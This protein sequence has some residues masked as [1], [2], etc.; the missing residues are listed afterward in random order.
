MAAE[1]TSVIE[2][3]RNLVKQAMSGYDCSHDFVHV[4]RVVN[5]S[6]K[7]AKK[8]N[9]TDN[10]SLQI[11]ELAAYLHDLM[12]HKYVSSNESQSENQN[13]RQTLIQNHL[14]QFQLDNDIIDKVQ[15]IVENIS[16]SKE[17]KRLS[18]SSNNFQ[19]FIELDIV[20]DADRLDAIGAIGIVRC[21]SFGSSKNR[22]LYYKDEVSDVNQFIKSKYLDQPK[23]S[24]TNDSSIQHFF[25]KLLHLKSMMK[26]KSGLEMAEQRHQFMEQ[27]IHQFYSE[28]YEQ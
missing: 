23:V 11:I 19:S 10:K 17:V 27:F 14:S 8:E 7:I 22:P 6:M 13:K 12:D 5:L 28:V 20:Q 16:F 24:G 9:V 3:T 21:F 26:T 4:E 15:F 25:D 18:S 1:W 2:S